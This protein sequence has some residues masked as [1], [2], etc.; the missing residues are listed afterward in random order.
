MTD[1]FQTDTM[2]FWKP[3]VSGLDPK[4]VRTEVFV[5][6]AAAA[7]EKAGSFTNTHRHIQWKWKVVDPPGAAKPDAWIVDQ[8]AKRLKKLYANSTAK[9]DRPILDMT[10]N[11]DGLGGTVDTEKVLKEINGYDLKT[12]KLLPT[13]GALRDDGT[14]TSGCW[15]YTGVY[16]E[17]K[18]K[19]GDGFKAASRVIVDPEKDYLQH[20]WGW[21]WPANRRILYNRASADPDGKSWSKRPLVWWDAGKKVWTGY[22]VPDFAPTN[23]PDRIKM[24]GQNNFIMKPWGAG[25][26]FGPLVDGPFPEHYEPV[27]SPV[28]NLLGGQQYSPKA[29]IYSGHE[30]DKIGDP[31]KFPLIVTTYRLTEHHLSGIMTRM[32]PWLAEAFPEPFVEMDPVLARKKGIANGDRVRVKSARGEVIVKAIVTDRLRPFTL[33]GRQ[34]H[35]VGLPIHWSKTGLVTADIANWLTPQFADPIVQIQ[36]SKVFLGDVEKVG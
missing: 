14:T 26:F 8:L 35:E 11:Y 4:Q 24:T 10:W 3:E 31:S 15:I 1:I 27:E 18:E 36:E 32:V 9:R 29:I 19:K 16:Q 28:K 23:A 17:D 22:D 30:T 13:F 34:V 12:G 20:G 5:L 25:A 21:T 6:P 33:D 7:A 2:S